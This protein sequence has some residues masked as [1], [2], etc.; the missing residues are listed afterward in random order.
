M[1]FFSPFLIYLFFI[2]KGNCNFRV[3]NLFQKIKNSVVGIFKNG[4]RDNGEGF[5]Q[6][7]LGFKSQI[8]NWKQLK[9]K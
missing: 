4:D 5:R 9:S 7:S 3:C 8:H 2:Q 6:K 1:A